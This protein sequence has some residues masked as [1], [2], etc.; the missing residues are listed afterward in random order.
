MTRDGKP[1]KSRILSVAV[2]LSLIAVVFVAIPKPADAAIYYTGTV[3]TTDD[4]GDPQDVFFR[5]D[6]VYVRVETYY[7]GE[8]SVEDIRVEIQET[9]GFV[10]D[11]FTAVTD[12]PEDGVYE[13]W[14]ADPWA[15]YLATHYWFDGEMLV[16]DIVVYVDTGG[17]TEIARV[18]IQVK[19]E[20]LTLEPPNW[21]YYYPGQE[22]TVTIVTSNT[23]DL[24][25]VQVVN[26]TFEDFENWTRLD[27]ADG[28]YSFVWV[29]DEDMPDGQY[30][31]NV[32][33]QDND[34]LW[35]T[36]NIGIQ[37][38]ELL[39]DSNQFYV[40][41][42]DTVSIIYDVVEIS[43]LTPY[44]GA[45]IEYRVEWLNESGNLTVESGTMP[46]ASG[47][48]GFEIPE[49]I[50]LYSDIDVTF[51]ANESD[52]RSAMSFLWFTIGAIDADVSVDEG[53]YVPGDTVSVQVDAWIGDD[54]WGWWEELQGAEVDI[55]IEKNGTMIAAYSVSGLVTDI[56]GVVMY[57]FDLS[58]NAAKGM[59][60][61]TA[62]VSKLG[63]EV[64]RAASFEVEWSGELTVTFDKEYYYSGQTA[65]FSFKVVWN[66]EEM[67]ASAVY[68][69]V[70]NDY[71]M[72]DT[73]NTSSDEAS[74]DIPVGYIGEIWVQATTI[75]EGYFL[76]GNDWADVYMAD[77]VV[78]PEDEYYRAGETITFIYEAITEIANASM[79]YSITDADGIRVAGGDLPFLLA[80]S[81]D[82]TVPLVE[83][84]DSYT[85]RVTVDDGHGHLVS[86]TATAWL[87]AQYEV[88]IWL[89]SSA[90]YTSRAFEPGST[91]VFGYSIAN[92]GA[93][94]LDVYRLVFYASYDFIDHNMLVSSPTGTF[95]VVVPETAGDGT[96]WMYAS[97]Q[98]PVNSDWLSSDSVS[99]SVKSEQSVWDKSIGGLSLFNVLV[100][101][102]LLLMVILLIVVPFLKGRMGAEEMPKSKEEALPKLMDEPEAPPPSE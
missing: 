26:D 27:T 12:D 43:T 99:F 101:A 3:Q 97:L 67:P 50:A 40:L 65:M 72:V 14:S 19:N 73:G 49:N 102:L 74:Y 6:Q 66:G 42:G 64:V 2:A 10:R 61:V 96:Y 62:T 83:P 79:S 54:W 81:V 48:Y 86:D 56:T 1:M 18:P 92:I 71:G 84:S 17:W 58:T 23:D 36:T 95:S 52:E 7:M 21:G 51:W 4:A 45:D 28:W 47:T 8:L 35:Y 78:Y 89:D 55:T 93:A 90:G 77:M 33:A 94:H 16:Y 13:S 29:I 53:P 59:Y 76:N 85:A 98:D 39:V 20:G 69:V 9:D 41:P 22:V 63:Y 15:E 57:E 44:D 60:V 31:M 91:V 32:R 37:K 24:F 30:T 82:F 87:Y 100:L 46:G 70:Y 75:L 34:A 38:Y 80:G 25:Y 11:W 5:G 68:Y 88:Q